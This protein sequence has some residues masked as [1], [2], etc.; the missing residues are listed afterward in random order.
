E[1]ECIITEIYDC[2]LISRK[3][4]KE[5]SIAIRNGK[6]EEWIN[7]I[8][9]HMEKVIRRSQAADRYYLYHYEETLIRQLQGT[10]ATTNTSS[11]PTLSLLIPSAPSSSSTTQFNVAESQDISS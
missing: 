1:K 9:E 7:D 11:S 10:S 5:K 2:L 4:F 6:S 3:L 8:D